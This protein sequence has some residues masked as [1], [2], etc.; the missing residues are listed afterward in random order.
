MLPKCRRRCS[1]KTPPEIDPNHRLSIHLSIQCDAKPPKLLIHRVAVAWIFRPKS[2]PR[3]RR[4][5]DC[6]ATSH[7]YVQAEKDFQKI[8]IQQGGR[9]IALPSPMAQ[10][11]F[12]IIHRPRPGEPHDFHLPG[13]IL[14]RLARRRSIRPALP[15]PV[16]QDASG[17]RVDGRLSR[18][19]PRL[20][21]EGNERGAAR[22][23][24]ALASPPPIGRDRLRVGV[25]EVS[26][27]RRRGAGAEGARVRARLHNDVA[28]DH[29]DMLVPERPQHGQAGI[30]C[31]AKG[32]VRFAALHIVPELGHARYMLEEAP[33]R[34][35]HVGPH[36]VNEAVARRCC[37]AFPLA[38]APFVPRR[39]MFHPQ[40]DIE[41][42]D[43]GALGIA[44]TPVLPVRLLAGAVFIDHSVG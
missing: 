9:I 2:S 15:V 10:S 38:L 13:G 11:A 4:Y 26:T 43:Q 24:E 40:D 36:F 27:C 16:A 44:P 23:A 8:A 7:P 18:F 35:R 21:Q 29:L 6:N 33:M 12:A 28:G 41:E 17:P 42:L 22:A 30:E 31:D 25:G 37:G 5:P 19:I 39:P 20:L 3:V 32:S 1:E 14:A 34:P